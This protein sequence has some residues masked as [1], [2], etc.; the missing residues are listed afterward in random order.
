M[1]EPLRL[2]FANQ[3]VGAF[4]LVLV[5]LMLAVGVYLLRA[6]EFFAAVRFFDL[7]I[8][9]EKIDGLRVGTEVLFLGQRAGR[10]VDM[11]YRD[12]EKGADDIFIRVAIKDSYLPRIQ[13]G[14][15]LAIR[16]K[17]GV[18]EPYLEIQRPGPN[19]P[20]IAEGEYFAPIQAEVDRLEQLSSE[21][22]AVR[23]V[24]QNVERETVPA[25][26]NVQSLTQST[27]NTIEK[28][29]SPAL[30]S[31]NGTSNTVQ[32]SVKTMESDFHNVSENVEQSVKDVAGEFKRAADSWDAASQH[33]QQAA[34]AAKA[35]IETDMQD[36]LNSVQN[37]SDRIRE[38]TDRITPQAVNAL[39]QLEDAARAI[40]EAT[41]DSRDVIDVIRTEARDLPGTT[42]RFNYGVATLQEVADA[43]SQVWP[44]RK[45]T[46]NNE[47][48]KRLSPVSIRGA[49][50]R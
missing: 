35:T 18:G 41:E 22:A 10:I 32:S 6:K 33:F 46:K 24:F 19:P 23:Q 43:A 14:S 8:P 27:Q 21:I 15:S 42:E 9:Q 1:N 26:K 25:L 36:T 4:V 49:S 37:T 38:N 30:E 44:I 39:R 7:R 12:L 48:T 34:D 20:P 16:R 3:I 2:R 11:Q 28:K 40:E 45:F 29:L 17:F 47:P 5:A 31:L 13:R 50:L